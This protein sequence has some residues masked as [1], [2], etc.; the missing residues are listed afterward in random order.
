MIKIEIDQDWKFKQVDKQEWLPATVP[1]CVHTDLL[2]NGQIEDPFFGANENK[3]QWIEYKNWEYRT[4]F[5]V[6]A[7]VLK[8]DEIELVFEGLDTYAS[9]YLN[10]TEL[11]VTYNMFSTWRAS[12]KDIIKFGENVLHI[13]FESPTNKVL[14]EM[15]KLDFRYHALQDNAVE[16][17]ALTRKAPYHYGWDWGP[18]FVTSGIWK[19]IILEARSHA[20]TDTI[21]IK[22]ETLNKQLAQLSLQTEFYSS[23]NTSGTLRLIHKGTG[24][25]LVDT[26][27]EIKNGGNTTTH[28]FELADPKLWYPNGYGEQHLYAFKV[29]WIE[30]GQV[31]HEKNLKIGLRNLELRREKDEWGESFEFVVNGV[32]IFAK[33]ANWIPADNFLDRVDKRRY[34]ELILASKKVHFNMLRVWGGGIYE[35]D[36]FY[37]LCDE[38]GILVWQ[39][40]MFACSLFPADDGFLESVKNE[41]VDNIKRLRNHASLALWCGNNENEWIY[42]FDGDGMKNRF[43]L[44]EEEI[45]VFKQDYEKLNNQLLKSL[46]AE[47]NPNLVYWPSSPSSDYK[48]PA[49]DD[50]YGDIHHWDVW[51]MGYPVENY[52]KLKPRFISEFGFQSMPDP[53]TIDRYLEEEQRFLGSPAMETHQ[54]HHRG[55]SLI[56]TYMERA[57][58]YPKDFDGFAYLS[59][60][61]QADYMKYAI[62]YFRSLMPKCMGILYWQLNDCW[63]VCSWASIDYDLRWK[64][65]H[66]YAKKFYNPVLIYAENKTEN[67][68][69]KLISDSKRINNGHLKWQLLNF[70]GAVLHNE[71]IPVSGQDV[72]TVNTVLELPKELLLKNRASDETYLLFE[73]MEDKKVIA[74]NRLFFEEPKKLKLQEATIDAT[75]EDASDVVYIHLSASAY[76]K[77]VFLIFESD[78]GFFEDNYFDMDANQTVTIKYHP[79]NMDFKHDIKIVSMK[80]MIEQ[81]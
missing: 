79:E 74:D 3:C 78:N 32:K 19:P 21:F 34:E 56:K 45:K 49:N 57:Y 18:R 11:L 1:G 20:K 8:E 12:V 44:K 38:H 72:N 40:F 35:S 51:H 15:A 43:G 63:P 9:I 10:D 23:K 27:V 39:D 67:V 62:E 13:R 55:Y 69:V 22:Q 58:P 16:A 7:Y 6:D 71:I 77:N 47:H 60:V 33:G 2:N 29:E 81:F 73:L 46:V 41:V 80:D 68:K 48:A 75:I 25:V 70:S 61:Q 64:A 42:D 31:V 66:Y 65:F 28:D 4:V 36:E 37:E 5:T 59:Q 52:K 26:E 50:N 76:A 24:T 17:S 54:K 53:R 30:D 14:P